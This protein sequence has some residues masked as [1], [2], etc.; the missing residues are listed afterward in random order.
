MAENKT[1]KNNLSVD[2]FIN[3]VQDNQQRE[4]AKKLNKII[5]EVTA[6]EPV[7]WGS[8]IIGYGNLPYKTADGKSHEW[9][10]VGF[11]PRK[12]SLTL[13]IMSGFEEY[14]ESNDY[15]PAPL[16][17]NL[18]KYSTGKSCLYIKRL[19]D[20]DT[21]VLKKLIKYSVDILRRKQTD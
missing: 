2:D 11:S 21:E 7:M 1:Q 15:N 9:M 3:S 16:L 5:K 10:L 6:E 19:N 8:S 18:G 4:D 14:A 13:Y 12:T 20:I 17:E